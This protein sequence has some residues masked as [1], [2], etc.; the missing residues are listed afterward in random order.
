MHERFAVQ[1]WRHRD[2]LELSAVAGRLLARVHANDTAS[3][4]PGA[5]AVGAAFGGNTDA[6]VAELL[7]FVDAYLPVFERD[8]QLFVHLLEVR[9]P[10]LGY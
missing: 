3:G 5:T 2:L 10:T 6:L 7:G 1:F 4:L 9:G 8:Y